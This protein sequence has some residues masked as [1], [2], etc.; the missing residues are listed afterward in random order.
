MPGLTRRRG[1]SRISL[2]SHC[3]NLN[4]GTSRAISI[5]GLS[6]ST[7]CRKRIQVLRMPVSP[8]GS[9]RRC[10]PVTSDK[11]RN[12]LSASGSGMLPT[13]CTTGCCAALAMISSPVSVQAI[14]AARRA[15]EQCRLLVGRAA[16]GDALEG[17]PEQLIAA[18]ALIDREVAFEHC[19]R[20][21][22]R[23]DA[24]LDIRPP[25]CRELFRAWRQFAGMH[26]EAEKPHAEPAELYMHIRAARELCDA[27]LPL[28]EDLV[29]LAGVRPDADRSADMVEDDRCLRK[30]ARQ[31]D[32]LAKLHEIHPGVEAEA[33]RVELGKALAHFRVEQEP[34]GAVDRGAARR[35]VRVRR[36]DVADAA[37]AAAAGED[38]RLQYLLDL[39][40]EHQIGVSDDAGAHLGLA[41]DLAGGDRGN[42]IGELDLAHR[43]ERR[44]AAGAIHRQPFEIDRRDDVM[45]AA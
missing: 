38:H 15:R 35:L 19:A 26:I 21:P 37:E 23:L 39:I 22:E 40:A 42:A 20:G 4:G 25:Q 11:V 2:P 9:R 18:A 14:K 5:A 8:S 16:R 24:G 30:G 31:I 43:L 34:G 7:S 28:G 3:T 36:G 27:V 32:K 33:E 1:I 45:A 44:R 13:K 10:G 41:K 17:I 6:A 29:A 12:T